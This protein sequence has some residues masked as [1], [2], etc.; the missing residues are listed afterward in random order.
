MAEPIR[1]PEGHKFTMYRDENSDYVLESQQEQGMITFGATPD[2]AIMEM[3]GLIPRWVTMSELAKGYVANA[4]EARKICK[5]FEPAQME[6][7]NR[8]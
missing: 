1:L 8:S 2:E 3:A 6:V 7:L 5:E 4:R